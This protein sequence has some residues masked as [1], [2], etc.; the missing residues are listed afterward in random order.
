[1]QAWNAVD[2]F[3]D[4][5]RDDHQHLVDGHHAVVDANDDAGKIGI[6][7]NRNGNGEGE[8]SADEHQ[9]DDQK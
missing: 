1:M 6:R 8:V 4:G 7:K 3:F 5:A 2:G 9:S